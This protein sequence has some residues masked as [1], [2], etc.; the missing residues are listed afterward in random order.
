MPK[1]SSTEDGTGCTN[2]AKIGLGSSL[3]KAIPGPVDTIETPDKG[4]V[5]ISVD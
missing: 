2:E 3:G 1:S 4:I 5:F